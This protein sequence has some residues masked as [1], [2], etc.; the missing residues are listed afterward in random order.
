MP[1]AHNATIFKRRIGLTDSGGSEAGGLFLVGVADPAASAIPAATGTLGTAT[2]GSLWRKTAGSWVSVSSGSGGGLSNPMPDDV[3][4][5]FGTGLDYQL[6]YDS[7]SSSFIVQGVGAD[8]TT[9]PLIVRSKGGTGTGGAATFSSGAVVATGG[10]A[11]TSGKVTISTGAA[12]SG[13][14]TARTGDLAL[15]VPTPTTGGTATRGAISLSAASFKSPAVVP[16]TTAGAAFSYTAP[17][18]LA[19]YAETGAVS[20]TATITGSI[21]LVTLRKTNANGGAGAAAVLAVAGSPVCTF[22]LSTSTE[23]DIFVADAIAAESF[24][25]GNSISLTLSGTDAQCS[26]TVWFVTGTD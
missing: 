12:T 16:V 22:D 20:S 5:Y 17:M 24:A 6:V 21:A 26:V 25:V 19:F 9:Q 10:A 18:I 23:D 15:T 11:A 4:F 3:P 8:A 2:D 14:G 1:Y 7:I 13:S